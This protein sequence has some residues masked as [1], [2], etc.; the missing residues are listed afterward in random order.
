MPISSG[1]QPA[2]AKPRKMPSGLILRLAASLSD[3]STQ[4][5]APSESWLAL[6]AVMN[7]SSPRTGFSL[8]RPSSV[9]SGAVALVALQRDGALGDL[10]GL[11]VL[12]RHD[13]G[14]RHD[15]GVEPAGLLAGG[16]ALLAHQRV[17]VLLLAADAVA[18]GDD[19]GGLDHRHVERALV[20]DDPL[21]AIELGV[22]VHLH[23]ADGLQPAGHRH[24]HAVL[25]DA[26]G[27][28]RDRLQAR[29]AEAV[30]GL[31]RGRDRQ[32]GADG[33]W[34]AMLP[35]VAPS[36]LAQPSV[37]SSTSPGSMPARLTA[38]WMTWPPMSAPWVRLKAPRT[39]LP[40]GVRAVE[41]MTA[42]TMARSFLRYRVTVSTRRQ[43]AS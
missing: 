38:C 8:A 4:A 20:L 25:R 32:S 7:W 13:R 9:V 17:L 14:H 6:P 42:S 31:A 24:R 41:T 18:L 40:I 26:A 43:L 11:L 39:A 35:P 36:G 10:L 19:V 34:R 5:E 3:I 28:E 2:T 37:T 15:L 21:V 22:H 12:D 29:G 1:S 33:A 23:E 30:D 27:G 16:R